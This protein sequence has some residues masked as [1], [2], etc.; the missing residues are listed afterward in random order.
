[1]PN[2]E[3]QRTNFRLFTLVA[4]LGGGF[5]CGGGSS[6]ATHGTDQT[7]AARLSTGRTAADEQARAGVYAARAARYRQLADENRQAV[8]G[9]TRDI[10]K[11]A[12]IATE[13]RTAVTVAPPAPSSAVDEATIAPANVRTK[14]QAAAELA[15]RLATAAQ[16]AADFH[17]QRAAEM[18]ALAGGGEVRR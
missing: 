10:E 8:A 18:A 3:S 17:A 16:K 1:V 9:L 13:T 15:D 5:S 12:V 6:S 2:L 14:R 7:V 4:L 11:Q